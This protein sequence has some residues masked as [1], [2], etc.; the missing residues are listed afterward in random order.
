MRHRLSPPRALLRWLLVAGG[1]A[2][3]LIA[4]NPA[5]E[6]FAEFAGQR[7][8]GLIREELCQNQGLPL[9]LRLVIQDCPGLVESQRPL[10]GRLALLH[11]QRRNLLLFS[12]YRTELGGQTLRPDWRLPRYH[13]LTFA[14]AGQFLVLRTSEQESV[15]G[16]SRQAW[17]PGGVW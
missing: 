12:L 6:A 11:T 2:L 10:L 1:I 8:S 15:E 3:G 4:T 14:A 9:M 17:L 16:A 7:L 5:P 13:S